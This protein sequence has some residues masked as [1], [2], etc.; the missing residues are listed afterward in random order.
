MNR[1]CDFKGGEGLLVN[2]RIYG[3]M[4]GDTPH[5]APKLQKLEGTVTGRGY[6]FPW[7]KHVSK[8]YQAVEIYLDGKI[9]KNGLE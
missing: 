3:V 5:W 2:K 6:D 8:P 9:L 1:I 4:N 7:P